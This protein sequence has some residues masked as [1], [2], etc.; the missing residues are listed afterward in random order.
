L[1]IKLIVKG[2]VADEVECNVVDYENS[3]SADVINSF[4]DGKK[5][6]SRE[7]L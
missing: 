7:L 5:D 4:I 1:F 6:E 2:F 3:I